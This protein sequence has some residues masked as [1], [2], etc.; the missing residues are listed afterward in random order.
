MRTRRRRG[1]S[2][3]PVRRRHGAL[4]GRQVPGDPHARGPRVPVRRQPA[5]R[6][7]A[8]V[9]RPRRD[10]RRGRRRRTRLRGRARRARS[11]LPRLVPRGARA[12]AGAGRPRGGRDLH[13]GQRRGP[14]APLL[15][16]PAPPS[17][18]SRSV[19][20]RRHPRGTDAAGSHQAAGGSGDQHLGPHGARAACGVLGAVAGRG[21]GAPG[22]HVGELRLQARRP[23][24]GRPA[25][26]RALSFPTPTSFRISVRTP[27]STP[28]CNV[29]STASTPRGSSWRG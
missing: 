3:L 12:T 17:A 23:A 5:H 29:T 13:R 11:A 1:A 19:R 15:G 26:R 14:R 7:A 25:A 2:A 21:G 4:G 18:G 8:G 16:D 10:R 28:T 27:G 24:G 20:P 22:G 6:A 9:R